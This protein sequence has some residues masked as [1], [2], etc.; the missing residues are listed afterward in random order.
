MVQECEEDDSIR[1]FCST[2]SSK[3]HSKNRMRRSVLLQIMRDMDYNLG[4]YRTFKELGLNEEQQ[5]KLG[6]ELAPLLVPPLLLASAID[7]LARVLYLGSRPTTNRA[8]FIRS[9]K[10]LFDL[11]DDKAEVMWRLR[12]SLSHA[13]SLRGFSF[14]RYGGGGHG[15]LVDNVVAIRPMRGALQ[16]AAVR[17]ERFLLALP[18]EDK[19]RVCRYLENE[20]FLYYFG[21]DMANTSKSG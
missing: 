14:V 8:M 21:D 7:S 9:A 20:G 4:V 6:N 12:N 10:E 1:E 16:A 17:L 2:E 5:Q 18:P 15:E 19:Q 3:I 13:Y 11:D